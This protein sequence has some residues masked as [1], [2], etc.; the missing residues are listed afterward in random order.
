MILYN[1]VTPAVR[2]QGEAV[3]VRLVDYLVLNRGKADPV[4]PVTD[5]ELMDWITS[6]SGNVKY[7]TVQTWLAG[8]KRAMVD[9]R[10]LISAFDT[11][12]FKAAM[13]GLKR[14]KGESPPRRALPLTLPHLV[15]LNRSV[16]RI[17][18]EGDFRQLD[19]AAAF[20]LGFA[21]FLRCGEFTYTD[22]DPLIH[23][24]RRDVNLSGPVPTVRVKYSKMDQ[25]GRGRVLPIPKV[26]AGTYKQVCPFRLLS[27]LFALFPAAPDAPLFSFSRHIP[28]FSSKLVISEFRRFIDMA[29]IEDERDSRVWSGNFLRRGAATWAAVVDLTDNAIMQLCRWS[30]KST[31]GGHQRYIDLTLQQRFNL[32]MRLYPAPPARRTGRQPGFD[33]DDGLDMDDGLAP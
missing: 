8:A 6:T 7:G 18:G 12:W 30:L 31:R 32:A 5:L 10:V 13:Q 24:Q 25:T 11:P 14:V 16:L 9:R 20:A 2:K 3:L 19:L 22:F 33:L 29:G 1:R 28:S 27:R 15:K 26:E 23:L 21:C 17:W 4:L